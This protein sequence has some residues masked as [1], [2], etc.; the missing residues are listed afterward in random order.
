MCSTMVE[1]S[2]VSAWSKVMT[3]DLS[4]DLHSF[5]R[6]LWRWRSSTISEHNP[7]Y[8]TLF[9][10]VIF[11]T[12]IT[13]FCGSIAMN[14]N[15]ILFCEKIFCVMYYEKEACLMLHSAVKFWQNTPIFNKW[16]RKTKVYMQITWRLLHQENGLAFIGK[17]SFRTLRFRAIC[18]AFY[19]IINRDKWRIKDHMLK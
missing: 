7:V 3:L 18:I 4:V 13:Y 10:K 15:M 8:E 6:F 11:V 2:T 16:I 17:V 5:V 9:Y 19:Q 12:F 1:L 14:G